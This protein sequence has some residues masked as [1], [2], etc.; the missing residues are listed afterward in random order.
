L[1][2]CTAWTAKSSRTTPI[3]TSQ[4]DHD[5]CPVASHDAASR[6][7]APPVTALAR[8]VSAHRPARAAPSAPT[9]PAKPNSPIRAVPPWCGGEREREAAPQR[10]ERGEQEQ[11]DQSA[12]QVTELPG[13][14]DPAE[15]RIRHAQVAADLGEHRLCR[16][17]ARDGDRADHGEQRPAANGQTHPRLRSVAN[18]N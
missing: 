16:V 4:S 5:A 10:A 12:R 2:T 11:R 13:R 17:D 18:C 14:D 15:A 1:L 7:R 3:T 9:R 6:T 8:P